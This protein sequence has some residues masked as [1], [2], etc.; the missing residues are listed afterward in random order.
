MLSRMTIISRQVQFSITPNKPL[1]VIETLPMSTI[2]VQSLQVRHID[3][4]DLY[5]LKG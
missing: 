4:V 2:E 5:Q 3:Q 1:I